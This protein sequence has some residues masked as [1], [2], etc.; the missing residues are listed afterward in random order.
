MAESEKKIRCVCRIRCAAAAVAVFAF[1]TVHA[2]APAYPVKPVRIIV[3]YAAGGNVD[4]N[5][6]ILGQKLTESLGQQVLVDN[7]AGAG[8]IIGSEFVAKS[9]PDGYTLLFAAA[10]NHT[11]NPSLYP[12]LP[13]DTVR[14][15]APISLIARVALILVVHP[16]LPPKSMKELITL[17]KAR[18]GEINVASGGN[19]T[20]GHL[21]LELMMAMS[22]T[23]FRHI[24]YKGNAPGL[25]DTIAGQTS[26]MIDTLSTSLAYVKAGRLRALAVTSQQRASLLP[27]IP[28]MAEAALPGYEAAVYIGLLAP[29][30]TPRD[31]VNRLSNEVARFAQN[32]EIRPRLAE[33]AIELIASTPE[34]FSAFI[35]TDIA[36]WEKV[37]RE[38][39]IKAE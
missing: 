1:G 28:T 4:V 25:A 32:P 8:G 13:Y 7:R 35:K 18:Q 14:D 26:M 3:P 39:G 12:K 16:S 33:Q 10:G 22:G 34:E 30:A 38:A 17:A 24:P 6:R 36:K 2:Q 21:A 29:A 9:A 23:K 11:I 27:A 15:F 37:I 19:G 31:I 20:A 5:A